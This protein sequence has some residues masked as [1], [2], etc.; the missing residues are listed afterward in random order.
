MK[1]KVVSMF[2][3]CGGFDLG[4]KWAGFKIVWANDISPEACATYKENVDD[5]IHCGDVRA[6]DMASIPSADV[7]IGGPPCQ[8]FSLVGKRKI[9]DERRDLIWDFV[10]A[11]KVLTPKVFVMENV[12]GLRSA[13][14]KS[15]MPLLGQLLKSFQKLG[16]SINYGILNA[17]NYGVPQ[18]RRR[19]V[20]IGYEGKR[21][22]EL[23]QISHALDRKITGGLGG[24][25]TSFD[26]L[27]DLP[28]PTEEDDPLAYASRP[29]SQY[30]KWSRQRSRKVHNHKRPHMSELDKK[31]ISHIPPGGNYMDVPSSIP[32]KRIKK[33]KQTGGR[34]TTYGRLSKD[35]PGYT[36]NTHFSRPNVGC[37]I[38]FKEDRLITIR[39][40]LR[41]QSFPDNFVLAQGM[42]K[43]AQY[44]LVGNAVPPLLSFA[45]AKS[46]KSQV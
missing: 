6:F 44:M 17:A 33:Y 13:V 18:L 16:Y 7:L 5:H 36:L 46:I 4:F 8:P 12:T 38:H 1:S 35:R 41:L 45:I 37:N 11:V 28:S 29:V 42:S 20:V 19:L 24:C 9:D 15:G 14:D 27:G 34:T 40:G 21:T 32:S 31:I 25:V 23:P 26:A 30:Q 2:S 22:L 43:R 3:G 39:E 10:N